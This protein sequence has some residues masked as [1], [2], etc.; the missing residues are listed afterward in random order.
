M[1]VGL[2]APNDSGWPG[3]AYSEQQIRDKFNYWREHLMEH[4]AGTNL[5][6]TRAEITREL[7]RWLDES[8][9]L[10]GR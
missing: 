10:R 7:D 5:V 3:E 2:L 4:L 9:D 6:I 8:L 1:A